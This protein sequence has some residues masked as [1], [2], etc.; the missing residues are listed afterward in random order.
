MKVIFFS[1]KSFERPLLE[2]WAR[3]LSVTFTEESL[4]CDTVSLARGY[5]AVSVFTGDD[6]SAQ[7]VVGLHRAGVRFV[8]IRAAGY[9]NVDVMRARDLGMRVAN[10]PAY[11]PN[12]VAEHA[13]ALMLALNRKLFLAREQALDFNFT[14]NSLIGFDFKNK[15]VGLVATGRI[16]AVVAKIMH[17]F[18]CRLL[19]YDQ[20]SDPQLTSRYQLEYTSLETLCRE[21]DIISLHIPLSE[22]TRYLID[23]KMIDLM[24]PGVMLVNTARGGILNTKDALEGVRSGRIG[25]L[26]L[27]VYENEKGLFFYDHSQD[28]TRD[29]LLAE[30][31]AFPNVV[32]TPHQGFATHEALDNIAETTLANLRA[33]SAGDASPHEL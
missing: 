20:Y 13:V 26:G 19:G 6:V 2:K 4:H 31:M 1:T 7:V 17:G 5:D 14:V 21:S 10:V 15:T 28:M 8:A 27:D 18:G 22:K 11:S 30:L 24:K 33:W 25:Y 12:A 16:G 3:K 23:K 9:D 29:E 32:V